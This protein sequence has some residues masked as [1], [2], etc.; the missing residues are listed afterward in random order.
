MQQN[1]LF[2][3]YVWLVWTSSVS[4]SI[5]KVVDK[6]SLNDNAGEIQLTKQFAANQKEELTD[7]Y[8]NR[9]RPQFDMVVQ[10]V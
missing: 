3:L 7:L 6:V 9:N 2:V 10:L 5:I 1:L 4:N 8:L